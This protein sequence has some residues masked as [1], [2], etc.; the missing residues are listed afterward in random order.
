MAETQASIDYPV[1]LGVWINWSLGG[2]IQG[3]T[4]TL[5]H[6]NGALLTAFLAIFI[7]F[8]GSRL[9]RII[10]FV[11]YR[12]L[13]GKPGIPHDGLYHQRQA[14]L[15]NS[16]DEKSGLISLFQILLAW[17]R[18]TYQPFQRLV[19]I[20]GVSLLVFVGITLAS[21]FSSRI[22]SNGGNEVLIS[23][24][25]CGTAVISK[26]T[27]IT[28]F[29]Q[30]YGP[31]EAERLTSYANYAQRCYSDSAEAGSARRTGCT[32]FVK[33]KLSTVVDRDAVCPFEETICRHKNGNIRIDTG[34][35]NSQHLGLNLP[36]ESQ[37][38][39]RTT[40]QCAT[41]KNSGYQ[42]VAFYS[43]DKPYIRYF[44]GA[45]AVAGL[46]NDSNPYTYEVEQ[47][48]GEEVAWRGFGHPDADY[49][50]Q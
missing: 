31:W 36:N 43:E 33:R 9:W 12:I 38:S 45:R 39:F 5:T 16:S 14:I 30:I 41:L 32:P 10:C 29:D 11:L 15:R 8:A 48:S 42:K 4:V 50:I 24:P 20:I 28:Q 13:L 49:G 27:T 44:Y 37:F 40:L 46:A 23:S 19:P 21:V 26:N 47:I 34:H 35:I 2:R 25:N 22:S 1:Y 3:S 17:R 6:R 7:T 18:R